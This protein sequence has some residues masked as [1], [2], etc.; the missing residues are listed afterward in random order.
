MESIGGG[1]VDGPTRAEA[2]EILRDLLEW[3]LPEHAWARPA[4]AVEAMAAALAAGD[5]DRL[6]AATAALEQLSPHRVE[7]VRDPAEMPPPEKVRDRVVFLVH[8]LGNDADDAA[9]GAAAPDGDGDA[10]RPGR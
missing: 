1:G 4:E 9:A 5:A 7:R 3:E 10:P 8:S 6:G 2:R